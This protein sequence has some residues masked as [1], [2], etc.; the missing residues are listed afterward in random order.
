[1]KMRSKGF[2]RLPIHSSS[3]FSISVSL[4]FVIPTAV[5]RARAV[6]S[7]RVGRRDL[8]FLLDG[9]LYS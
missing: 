2:C 3:G 5:E 1:M 7:A 8:V 6:I 4:Q 9:L